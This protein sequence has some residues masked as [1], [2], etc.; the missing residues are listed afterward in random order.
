TSARSA[1]EAVAAAKISSA[2]IAELQRERGLSAAYLSA[3][4][5]GGFE[6]RLAA[7]RN[8]TNTALDAFEEAF[9]GEASDYVES[10]RQS[11]GEINSIRDDV[12]RLHTDLEEETRVYKE[13]VDGQLSLINSKMSKLTERGFGAEPSAYIAVLRT[14]EMSGL[15]RSMGATGFTAGVFASDVYRQFLEFR[16]AQ[17]A[18]LLPALKSMPLELSRD[19]Q[20]LLNGPRATDIL[21]FRRLADSAGAGAPVP[22]GLGQD[23]FDA[24]TDRVD[25][26]TEVE[27]ALGEML[28]NQAQ[29]MTGSALRGLAGT[30][31]V[32]LACIIGTAVFASRSALQF[33]TVIKKLSGSLERIG[34]KEYDFKVYGVKRK[35]E[36]G[37]M[38]R[39]LLDVREHLKAGEAAN[40]EATYKGSGFNGSSV[41]MMIAD[42]NLNVI[43]ANEA[44]ADFFAE[45]KAAFTANSPS[46]DLDEVIGT[47][48]DVLLKDVPDH[49]SLLT[50]PSRLPAAVNIVVGD[51]RIQ[52][53]ISPVYS[54]D[55]ECVGSTLEW[56]DVTQSSLNAGILN[57]I[58]DTQALIE[59]DLY[60]NILNANDNFLAATGYGFEEIK[61]RHHRIF[62]TD[63]YV[64]S[65]NY[66]EMWEALAEGKHLNERVE[67]RT[68]NG[69]A[70]FLDAAYN[71]VV[72]GSGKPFKVVKI[73]TDVTQQELDRRAAEVERQQRAED[74]NVVVDNLASG[75]ARISD[76]DFSQKI[77]VDVAEEY[78][79]LKA[80]FNAAVE[81]LAQADIEAME[82]KAAQDFVVTHLEKVLTKLSD[83][84]LSVRLTEPF[85]VSYEAMRQNFN[86]ALDTLMS[87]MATVDA[88][89]KD[90]KNGSDEVSRANDDMSMRT[91]RQAA[92]LEETTAAITQISATAS[93]SAKGAIEVSDIVQETTT[94]AHKSGEIVDNAVVAM[95]RIEQSSNEISSIINVID[96]IAFQT[97]LLALN[98]GVEAARAGDAG[99]GFAVVAQEVRGLAQRC[100]EAAKEIKGLI[101]SSAQNVSDG[102]G[103]V[104]STGEA[105]KEIAVRIERISSLA[106]EIAA[107]SQEQSSAL[108]EVTKAVNE[109][110]TVTQQ[111]AAMVEETTAASHQMREQAAKLNELMG[112]FTLDT[113]SKGAN[114]TTESG[115]ASSQG[116]QKQAVVAEGNVARLQDVSGDDWEDF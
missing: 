34:R 31:A 102:V 55:G 22:Q 49:R 65:P 3:N 23:W 11:L 86:A 103:L 24:A 19:A 40:I 33:V 112:G 87:A 54:G 61:G 36:L 105:L 85:E 28:S 21:K 6:E 82:S 73:A 41:A 52:V 94:E 58:N 81:K 109:L 42:T 108:E 17:T 26:F 44:T 27:V 69:D 91:E 72:D 64:K 18:S 93:Q 45:R 56:T 29:S 88:T 38:A 107:S 106:T 14:K 84:D 9:S 116:R 67:R 46:F 66:K 98:A 47:S 75:L 104:N 77:E 10:A 37:E 68:K 110:D 113:D 114:D 89:G 50:D 63:E 13:M 32:A 57:A 5:G 20:S 43:Y 83:G 74:L 53:N 60:G 4:G 90:I 79:A 39:S 96:D 111:N 80:D 97:N 78:T 51:Y 1:T 71:P 7:Q 99:K 115:R 92:T 30:I 35:D 8:A 25:G 76:G 100:T 48:V 70:L 59:F 2:L 15:E 101:S 16:G 12:D 95:G 62:C